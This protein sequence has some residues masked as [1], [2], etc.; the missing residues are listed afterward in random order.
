MLIHYP[1][2]IHTFEDNNIIIPLIGL[3]ELDNLKKKE[4]IVGYQAREAIREINNVR[5][6]GNLHN[7]VKLPNGGTLRVELNHMSSVD[8]SD[9]VDLNKNDNKILTIAINIKNESKNVRTILVTK[10]ICVAVK[11]QE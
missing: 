6:Y 5:Q 1:G 10:D 8:I 2:C 7:G 11:A 4:G 9:G 3:E